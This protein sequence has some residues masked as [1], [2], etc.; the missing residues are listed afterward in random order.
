MALALRAI[1]SANPQRKSADSGGAGAGTAV[2]AGLLFFFLATENQMIKH[3]AV[4][5]SSILSSIT[6]QL[7]GIDP[8]DTYRELLT[9]AHYYQLVPQLVKPFSFWQLKKK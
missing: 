8:L 2:I 5:C 7:S 9:V 3:V 6:K 1:D 4:K